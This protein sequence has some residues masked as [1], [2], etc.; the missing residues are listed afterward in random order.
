[1]DQ[2]SAVYDV[3]VNRLVEHLID[4]IPPQYSLVIAHELAADTVIQAG[5][6]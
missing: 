4:D 3:S 2:A 1:M 6:K 5:G